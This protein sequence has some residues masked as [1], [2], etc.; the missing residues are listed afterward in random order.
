MPK[1]SHGITVSIRTG[2]YGGTP[3]LSLSGAPDKPIVIMAERGA[4][5]I[6]DVQKSG[7]SNGKQKHCSFTICSY[8][9]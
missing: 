1:L 7:I 8:L 2:I 4:N 6:K 5:E 3:V 9:R